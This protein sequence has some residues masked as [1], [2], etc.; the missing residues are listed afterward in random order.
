MFLFTPKQARAAVGAVHLY[1]GDGTVHSDRSATA[2]FAMNVVDDPSAA[3]GLCLSYKNV[4][5]TSNEKELYVARKHDAATAPRQLTD[6]M[7]T[8]RQCVFDGD[9][10]V[11]IADR[12]GQIWSMAANL[13]TLQEHVEIRR[14][15]DFLQ[16]PFGIGFVALAEGS[17]SAVSMVGVVFITVFGYFMSA[18]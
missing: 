14:E 9:G 18:H 13:N 11:Y 10:T 6:G 15:K 4:F 2:K 8:P 3:T 7:T 17:A 12:A 16:D 1:D 5:Y